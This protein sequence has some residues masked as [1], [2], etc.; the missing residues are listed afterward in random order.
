MKMLKVLIIDDEEEF[1]ET[2]AD[3]FRLR[4]IQTKTAGDGESA[5]NLIEED[6]PEIVVLDVMMPGMGGLEVLKR[7][8]QQ[9]PQITVVLLTG[10]GSTKDGIQGMQL[11]AADY[12]MKPIDID[13]LIE[14]IGESLNPPL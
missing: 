13:E 6:P 12:L 8:K 5:L 1:L 3:R 2:L 10:R 9:H 11:G 14:K 4:G 7:I